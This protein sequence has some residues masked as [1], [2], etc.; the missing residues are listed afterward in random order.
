MEKEISQNTVNENDNKNLKNDLIRLIDKQLR[1]IFDS[2]NL[3]IQKQEGIY[4]EL[5]KIISIKEKEIIELNNK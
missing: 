1:E 5:R 2:F 4:C 3:E